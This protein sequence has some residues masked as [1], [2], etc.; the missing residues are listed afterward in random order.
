MQPLSREH[1]HAL[2]LCWKIRNGLS[3]GIVPERIKNYASWF[4]KTQ[5]LPHFEMEERLLFP[6]LGRQHEG[7]E[8]ALQEHQ[9]IKE[10]LESE[11]GS[12]ETLREIA[13]KL[14]THIRFEERI[15]FNEI[16]QAAS[17]EDLELIAQTHSAQDTACA[18]EGWKDNFWE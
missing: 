17:E 14:E 6:M 4:S 11:N 8:R 13:D 10:L 12:T 15:L 18:V 5:L 1:H 7:I 3:K 9:T 2:L 16:Q